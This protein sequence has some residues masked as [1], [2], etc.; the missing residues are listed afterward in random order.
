MFV[1]EVTTLE[2]GQQVGPATHHR[3][4]LTQTGL[5]ARR[6]AWLLLITILLLLLG[7]PLA[8]YFWSHLGNHLRQSPLPPSDHAWLSGPLANV[9]HTPEIGDDCQACH[10]QLF[11]RAPDRGCLDCHA[12][13][14]G[15]VDRKA[16]SFQVWTVCDA[17][18]VTGN[19]KIRLY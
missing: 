11:E 4:K 14:T 13:V 10:L 2:Q 18:T 1:L 6:P 12:H 9:H 17:P 3:I 8:G 5:S 19:T 16:V 7:A 15:H